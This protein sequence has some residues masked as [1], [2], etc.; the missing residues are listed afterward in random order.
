MRFFSL[1]YDKA[2]NWSRHRHAPWFLGAISF[3]ESSFFPIPPDVMLAPMSLAAP[4]RAWFFALLT[5]L[6]SVAGGAFGYLIGMLAFEAV[7]PILHQVGYWDGFLKV[8][9]WF[10]E[11]GIWVIFIA[12]F[13]PIPYKL[14]TIG[15]GVMSMAFVPFV[16]TSLVGRGARFFMVAGLMKWGG[17]RME[18]MLRHYVDLIGWLLV[19]LVV[20]LYLFSKFS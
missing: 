15:A 1:L 12:A 4:R 17:E 13:S 2:L 20:V 11:E 9:Q 8:K 14:F 16:L 7:E 10:I 3:A 18:R 5:T 6:T 19:V